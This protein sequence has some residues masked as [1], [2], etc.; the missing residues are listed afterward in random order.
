MRAPIDGVITRRYP[1]LGTNVVRNDKLFEVAKLAPLQVRFHLPQTEKRQLGRGQIISLSAINSDR[2]IAQARVRRLDPV[3]NPTNNTF[4]Y[5]ADVIGGRFLMP[6]LAVNV[7]LPGDGQPV[8]DFWLP[9]AAFPARAELHSDMSSTLFI[10][11]GKKVKSR[12]VMISALEGDQVQV[13]SGLAKDDRV[14]VPPPAELKD[15]DP[16]EISQE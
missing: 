6:G 14:V 5:I 16:V 1:A 13:V 3:A 7:Q 11:E 4:G 10:V 9:R 8:A 12:E 2:V 15:G